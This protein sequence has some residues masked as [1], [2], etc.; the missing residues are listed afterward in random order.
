MT[1]N[2]GANVTAAN[3]TFKQV[4]TVPGIVNVTASGGKLTKA[5][6]VVLTVSTSLVAAIAIFG[7][8]PQVLLTDAGATLLIT[9]FSARPFC[10]AELGIPLQIAR[11]A[12]SHLRFI[13][14]PPLLNG[15]FV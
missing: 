4:A 13:T 15:K 9:V 14:Q 8:A 11:S 6:D 7:I 5:F 2:G 3:S 10:C 1:L 12:V